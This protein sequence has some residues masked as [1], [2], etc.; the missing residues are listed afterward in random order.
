MRGSIPGV[1]EETHFSSNLDSSG[2][3]TGVQSVL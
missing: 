3:G 1:E 2:K